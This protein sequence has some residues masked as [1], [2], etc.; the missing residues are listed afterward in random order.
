MLQQSACLSV[1]VT[2]STWTHTHTLSITVQPLI[3]ANDCLSNARN[4]HVRML[5]FLRETTLVT[6]LQPLL[7]AEQSKCNDSQGQGLRCN[8]K[9]L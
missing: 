1:I 3:V 8:A 4:S 6:L 2:V 5:Q 9:A 7:I